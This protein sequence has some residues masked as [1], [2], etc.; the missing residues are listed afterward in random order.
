MK[1]SILFLVFFRSSYASAPLVDAL[2]IH[3]S[4]G[5]GGCIFV[6]SVSNKQII[7]FADYGSTAQAQVKSKIITLKTIYSNAM[8]AK[9]LGDRIDEKFSNGEIRFHYSGVLISKFKPTEPLRDFS[10][11]TL[12]IELG[13][14]KET[15]VV[16]ER[17]GS[18]SSD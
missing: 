2:D 13:K 6:D 18:F 8:N 12:M 15:H 14:I 3:K 5:A 11:G 7:L 16:V 17:C 4:F 9:E 1:F 10:K